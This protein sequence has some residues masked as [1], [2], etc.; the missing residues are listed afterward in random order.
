MR[1]LKAEKEMSE[2]AEDMRRDE[3]YKIYKLDLLKYYLTILRQNT[4]TTFFFEVF[5]SLASK[6]R[7]K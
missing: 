7:K 1:M 3:K 4:D 6:R 5:A 2:L